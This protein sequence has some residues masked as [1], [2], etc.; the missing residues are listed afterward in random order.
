MRA[1][2]P[3]GQVKV[4]GVRVHPAEVETHLSAHPAVR[5]AVVIGERSLGRTTL[6]ADV[7]PIGAVTPGEL[8]RHLRESPAQPIRAQPKLNIVS[9]EAELR[10][11][12]AEDLLDGHSACWPPTTTAGWLA[13][14]HRSQSSRSSAGA[15][16]E[17]VHADSDFFELG[18]DSLLATRVLS[19]VARDFGTE[20]TFDD[21]VIAPTPAALSPRV[22][23]QRHEQGE[24]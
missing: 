8:E 10:H 22:V 12:P 5:G 11:V 21:F 9:C 17:E 3:I 24:A 16:T 15:G 14:E 2:A 18:G 7:V 20:L 23:A 6:A 1:G 19:A 4:L 13:D